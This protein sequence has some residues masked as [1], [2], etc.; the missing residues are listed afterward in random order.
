VPAVTPSSR[1]CRGAATAATHRPRRRARVV[2]PRGRPGR[3]RRR[4]DRR[5]LVVGQLARDKLATATRVCADSTCDSAGEAARANAYL[6]Q[7][8]LRGDIAT[9]LVAAGIAGLVTGGVLWWRH[10][11]TDAHLTVTGSSVALSIGGTL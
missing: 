3:A 1:H 4:R 8:R 2:E 7:S 6:A 10:R 11:A 5:G 9:G